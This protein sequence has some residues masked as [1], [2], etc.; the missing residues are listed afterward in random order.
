MRGQAAGADGGSG[1]RVKAGTDPDCDLLENYF[2]YGGAASFAVLDGC[3]GST[4]VC[5]PKPIGVYIWDFYSRRSRCQ[6]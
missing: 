1:L 4:S 5:F 6:P 3:V 2:A